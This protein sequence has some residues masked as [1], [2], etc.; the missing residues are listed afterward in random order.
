[1]C[2]LLHT[3]ALQLPYNKSGNDGQSGDKTIKRCQKD[4]EN[5]PEMDVPQVSLKLIFRGREQPSLQSIR[6]ISGPD[7]YTAEA[8]QD[9]D[10][11]K[12]VAIVLLLFRSYSTFPEMTLFRIQTAKPTSFIDTILNAKKQSQSKSPICALANGAF[13]RLFLKPSPATS[14]YLDID[15]ARLK[16]AAIEIVLDGRI[17]SDPRLVKQMGA[18]IASRKGWDLNDYS[19]EALSQGKDAAP[20]SST[21]QNRSV[22]ETT[23]TWDAPSPTVLDN[24]AFI[25]IREAIQNFCQDGLHEHLQVRYI[26]ST[27]ELE[28]L[29]E[30]DNAAYGE[31]SITYEKFQ[32]WWFSYPAGLHALFFRTRVMGAIGIWP[33]SARLAELFT[34]GRTKESQLNGRAMRPFM[35]SP[36]QFWYISGIV[37][38]SELRGGRA[39]KILLSRGIGCWL[40][41]A[42]I[43][44]PC[45]LLALAYSEQGRALLEGFDFFKLQNARAMPDGVP[46]FALQV[47]DKKQLLS[48]LNSRGVDPCPP[49]A[50]QSN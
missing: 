12:A 19:I 25:A 45:E 15:L 39:I 37:L 9:R 23:L 1:V 13:L 50:A 35:N 18:L 40:A 33:L 4:G 38:R 28:D 6:F 8:P 43:D 5:A 22:S 41:S 49:A 7:I 30:I 29:W 20:T 26:R 32:D 42:R 48:T 44:F 24:P 36:A 14:R 2:S 3:H 34:N 31:A 47:D 16:S 46:L 21:Q 17:V 10:L 27:A 11:A